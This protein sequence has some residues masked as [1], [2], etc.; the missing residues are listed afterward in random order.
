M[1]DSSMPSQWIA[2]LVDGMPLHPGPHVL[3]WSHLNHRTEFLSLFFRSGSLPH[4]SPTK[5][6]SRQRTANAE[7]DPRI[8]IRIRSRSLALPPAS[9]RHYHIACSEHEIGL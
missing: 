9:P 7:R 8:G 2:R 6:A 1:I 3:S 5:Y 4:A